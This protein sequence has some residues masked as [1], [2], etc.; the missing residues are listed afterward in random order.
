MTDEQRK[1]VHDEIDT[2]LDSIE[3]NDCLL[4]DDMDD[5][6]LIIENHIEVIKQILEA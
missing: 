1:Q 5:P 2:M 4:D 3:S 6:R